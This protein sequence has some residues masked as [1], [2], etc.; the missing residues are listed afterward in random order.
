MFKGFLL[1]NLPAQLKW[2]NQNQ[3]SLY[4]F[5]IANADKLDLINENEIFNTKGQCGQIK[6][7]LRLCLDLSKSISLNTDTFKF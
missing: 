7:L 5:F 6:D 1:Q 2:I 3:E 4:E